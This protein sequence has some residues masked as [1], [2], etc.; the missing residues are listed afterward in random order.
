MKRVPARVLT[1]LVVIL[2]ALPAWGG[3]KEKDEETI[4]KATTV[5]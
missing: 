1:G 3:D 5:L 2:L 4:K